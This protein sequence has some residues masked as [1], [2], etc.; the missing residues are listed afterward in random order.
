MAAHRAITRSINRIL[1]CTFAAAILSFTGGRTAVAQTPTSTSNQERIA[2]LAKP[3]VVQV[4]AGCKGVFRWTPTGQTFN[5]Q[6]AG[7]GSGF[8][9]HPSGYIAT[10]A[11]VTDDVKNPE[12][13]EEALTRKFIADL[14]RGNGTPLD[15]MT[16]AQRETFTKN[17]ISNTRL[18][19]FESIAA[20]VLPNGAQL[21]YDIKGFGAPVGE[22]KDVS[23]VKVETKN[24]PTL[25]LADSSK[26]RLQEHVTVA[27]YPAAAESEFLSQS[28]SLQASFT[29]GRVSSM[30][31]TADGSPVFQVDAPSSWG[32]S[33]GPVLNDA[34]EV[35]GLLT[36]GGDTVGGQ[37]VQGFTFVVA[38]NTV[39][40]FIKQAGT[41]NED[42]VVNRTY[43]EGMELF[44]ARRY[45]DAIAKFVETK[46]L[47]AQHSEVDRL[48]SESQQA[49]TEGRDVKA[50]ESAPPSS[51]APKSGDDSLMDSPLVLS[52]G[53]AGLMALT[54][55]ATLL[56]TRRGRRRFE[57]RVVHIAPAQGQR[58][59]PQIVDSSITYWC[60][61]CGARLRPDAQFCSG[62]GSKRHPA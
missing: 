12:K 43:R 39:Q 14:A 50:P 6:V 44:W 38:S 36:F 53:A 62:C 21:G 24:A 45:S 31:N 29:D 16:A 54:A 17:A 52:G 61:Q 51:P 41:T 3:A 23:I 9:L 32:N 22:G 27:G 57:P 33:G 60:D 42:S 10:N 11:H 8:F 18:S 28:S 15:R 47:F 49:I 4:W 58:P 7:A 59:P 19:N 2:V 40:E 25:K 46:W 20:V 37:A 30:K 34:G 26:V 48:I 56:Y 1:V 35:V 13:C 5:K 55:A